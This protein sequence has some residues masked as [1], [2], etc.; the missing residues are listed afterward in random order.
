ML[1]K[2]STILAAALCAAAALSTIACDE[3]EPISVDGLAL[4][5]PEG[6]APNADVVDF[7]EPGPP[8]AIYITKMGQK[9]IRR[10]NVKT[11]IDQCAQ[12][13]DPPQTCTLSWYQ[14]DTT[15]P[16]FV[17]GLGCSM[18]AT[19]PLFKCYHDAFM[20]YGAQGI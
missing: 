18:L 8:S 3:T 13:V 5:S 7:R 1:L 10:S 19:W 4:A 6:L 9:Y 15:K 12:Q 11:L 16:D 2:R 20:A 17:L 14:P